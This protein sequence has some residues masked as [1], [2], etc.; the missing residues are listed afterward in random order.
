M[1]PI[2]IFY[3]ALFKLGDPSKVLPA[4]VNIVADQ[5]NTLKESGLLAAA[6]QMIVGI[7]GGD[8][9]K[10]LAGALLPAQAHLVFHGLQCRNECRTIRIIEEW[11]PGHEDWYVLYHHSKGATK[12]DLRN[13]YWRECM[14]RHCVKEW[15]KCVADLE[16]GYDAVGCHWFDPPRTPQGQHIFAGTFFWSK[17]SYLRTLPSIM[18]RDRIKLSGIDSIESRYESE[19]WIGNGPVQ[20]RVKDYHPGWMI[21]ARPHP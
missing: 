13:R 3:H 7:N 12:P 14:E 21:D 9:S 20:P 8:E 11:L 2:A 19:V 4:A 16:A 10:P 17:A 6:S 15:R 18:D 1:K 5:M